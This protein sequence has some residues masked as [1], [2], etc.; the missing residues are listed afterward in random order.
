MGSTVEKLG[1]AEFS[2]REYKEAIINFLT[3]NDG[4]EDY[5]K[6]A[7]EAAK[8]C[9]SVK[10]SMPLLGTFD[11]EERVIPEKEKK[12]RQKRTKNTEELKKP[13]KIAALTKSDK[14]AEKINSY[15]VQIQRICQKRGSSVPYNELITDPGD[16]MATIDNAFQVA[17]L[18]R[19]GLIKLE[20]VD[21]EPHV[22]VTENTSKASQ[23]QIDP[24]TTSQCVP[25][26]NPK[27][28][29]VR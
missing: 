22:F 2:D 18:I 21:E 28:W 11:K 25:F 29:K 24:S 4:T 26:F 7:Q 16:F 12:E 13:E 9:M 20:T 1:N 27:I 15:N 14:G 23:A 8:C 5:D 19:D 17:F 3:I 10:F 6:L